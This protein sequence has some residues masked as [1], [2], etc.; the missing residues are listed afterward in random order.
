MKRGL[1]GKACPCS[2]STAAVKETSPMKRGLK[3]V[4]L[5]AGATE[6]YVKET[7]PMKRGLKGLD[8]ERQ[9]RRGQ[10]KRHPR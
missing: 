3:V 4:G 10:L 5:A 8:G 7:S 2:S 1:K 6:S 9:R